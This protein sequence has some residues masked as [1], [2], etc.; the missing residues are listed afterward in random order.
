MRHVSRFERQDG[1]ASTFQSQKMQPMKCT[2]APSLSITCIVFPVAMPAFAAQQ[3]SKPATQQ[4]PRQCL[5][6]YSN[7]AYKCTLARLD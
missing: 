2:V 1:G 6:T 7:R 3:P 4:L 5:C